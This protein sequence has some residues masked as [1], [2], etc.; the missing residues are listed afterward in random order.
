MPQ[1]IYQILKEIAKI[2]L[3]LEKE[4]NMKLDPYLVNLI[5]KLGPLTRSKV[6]LRRL[7]AHVKAKIV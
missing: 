5:S 3:I 7:K 4:N 2:D 1:L 6:G